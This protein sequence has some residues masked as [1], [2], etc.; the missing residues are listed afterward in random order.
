MSNFKDRVQVFFFGLML[1]LLIGGGFFILKLDDY[2]K[3]LSFYKHLSLNSKPGDKDIEEKPN[4]ETTKQKKN[5]Y[6]VQKKEVAVVKADSAKSSF[7]EKALIDQ[8]EN[9]TEKIQPD[10]LQMDSTNSSVINKE[11]EDIVVKKDELL[12]VKSIELINL[13]PSEIN[14]ASAKDSLLQKVS[15]V[16]DDKNLAKAAN[17]MVE[18]WISPINYRGYKMSKNKVALFGI[19]TEG[20]KL[21]KMDE[22]I[23][24]KY[25]QNV[26]KLDLT[27]D[28]KPFEK[29]SDQV[30]IA[31][32]N[33]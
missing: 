26:Y 33:K 21:Y 1:G 30:L 18:F 9:P 14:T 7:P 13:N 11:A 17:L 10:S 31:K 27:N 28:F 32:L 8:K 5:P 12:S 29:V 16:R 20:A 19:Q 24:L 25:Q 15:G 3:E 2:F 4:V 22:A 6:P 23:Y